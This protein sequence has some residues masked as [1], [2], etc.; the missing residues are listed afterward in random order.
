MRAVWRTEIPEAFP[1]LNTGVFLFRG[2]PAVL[3]LLRAWSAAFH[4]AGLKKDQVTLRELL[5]LSD[6][7]LHVLPPEYNLRHRKYL[8]VWEEREAVPRIL[9]FRRFDDASASTSPRWQKLRRRPH[10]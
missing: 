6:L 7:R 3:E 10:D 5:W 1:Q 4:E 9:H 8:R 2:T